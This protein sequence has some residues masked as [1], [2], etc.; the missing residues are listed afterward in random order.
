MPQPSHLA[1]I[2]PASDLVQ[3]AA[4][5]DLIREQT[6]HWRV[7][8]V[9]GN[10]DAAI[11]LYCGDASVLPPPPRPVAVTAMPDGLV[12]RAAIGEF[13][14]GYIQIL[15][16]KPVLEATEIL[17]LGETVAEIGIWVAT[18]VTEPG[19]TPEQSDGYYFRLWRQDTNGDWKIWRETFN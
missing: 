10:A 9:A 16:D 1:A 7:S 4:I 8:L 5:T 19:A 14:E 18:H 6:E 11:A 12:G 13:V 17:Q 15:V 3:A 2:T